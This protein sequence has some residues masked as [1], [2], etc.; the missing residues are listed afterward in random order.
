[1][2]HTK[3]PLGGWWATKKNSSY[4]WRVANTFAT[5]WGIKQK[6]KRKKKNEKLFLKFTKKVKK[7]DF[8]ASDKDGD[9]KWNHVAY[10]VKKG[11]K[12]KTLNVSHYDIKI[13]QH[14]R[15]YNSWTSNAGTKGNKCGWVGQY[16]DYFKS[17]RYAIIKRI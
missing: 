2:R 9:G 4:S 16:K 15:D 14:S 3:I 17:I 1:M 12:K 11:K 6:F 10:V 8:I 7:G 5:Y 13:A